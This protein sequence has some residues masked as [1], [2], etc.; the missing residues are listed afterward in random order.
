MLGGTSPS[1][2]A[3][4]RGHHKTLRCLLSLPSTQKGECE[5]E[6]RVS[7]ETLP[8][9]VVIAVTEDEHGLEDLRGAG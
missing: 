3:H 5:R 7:N 1:I 8:R 4:H 6:C 2:L 9:R